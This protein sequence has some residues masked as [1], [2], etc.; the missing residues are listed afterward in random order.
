MSC[1]NICKLMI[2]RLDRKNKNDIIAPIGG[3]FMTYTQICHEYE[4]KYRFSNDVLFKRFLDEF[5]S[6]SNIDRK[7]IAEDYGVM[8]SDYTSFFWILH[9]YLF[10]HLPEQIPNFY[11]LLEKYQYNLNVDYVS[12]LRLTGHNIVDEL[13][14]NV[15]DFL[16]KTPYIEKV[17]SHQGQI[18]IHSEKLGN[19]TFFSTAKYFCNNHRVC[20][21]L[22]HFPSIEDCHNISWKLMSRMPKSTLITSLLPMPFE[23]TCYHTVV[24]NADGMIVDAANGVVL[25]ESFYHQLFQDEVI[26]ETEDKDLEARLSS[27]S[28]MEGR[29]YPDAL[30]LALHEQKKRL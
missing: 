12:M 26:V 18:T 2:Q 8:E 5:C 14:D 24:R 6:I 29:S 9:S 23:G 10:N 27:T 13:E 1:T 30:V 11:R 7:L 17:S 20:Y 4:N 25:E 15:K 21:V 3:Q 22:E 28:L 16:M 19:I